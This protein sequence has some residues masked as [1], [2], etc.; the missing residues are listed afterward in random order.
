MAALYFRQWR[1]GFESLDIIYST[2]YNYQ[3]SDKI[4]AALITSYKAKFYGR[5]GDMVFKGYESMYHFT[6][7]LL[8]YNSELLNNL[9]DNACK[10]SGNFLFEPV[11]LSPDAQVPD[12]IENKKLFFFHVQQGTVKSIN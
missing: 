5:P 10:I 9:S 7:M 3:R 12:Y 8:K 1:G 4:I 11:K 2:P 6:K